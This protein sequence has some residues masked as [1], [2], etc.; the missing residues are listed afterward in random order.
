MV[1]S[2][3]ESKYGVAD[4]HRIAIAERRIGNAQTAD[5]GSIL[6][7]KVAQPEAAIDC[8]D[9][10]VMARDGRI[11]HYNIIVERREQTGSI[12]MIDPDSLK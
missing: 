7:A 8:L 4:A 10:R 2:G 3:M 9:R 12:W 1:E 6:A 5:E 11:R